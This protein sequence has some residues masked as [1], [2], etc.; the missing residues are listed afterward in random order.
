LLIEASKVLL[1]LNFERKVFENIKRLTSLPES[2][3]RREKIRENKIVATS[4]MKEVSQIDFVKGSQR[5]YP[6]IETPI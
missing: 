2:A 5:R 6:R 3:E 4:G 1:L